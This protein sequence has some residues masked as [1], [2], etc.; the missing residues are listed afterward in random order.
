MAE[1][2]RETAVAA[3]SA[4]REEGASY[5]VNLLECKEMVSA[6]H[7]KPTPASCSVKVEFPIQGNSDTVVRPR[8][9][10]ASQSQLI[11]QSIDSRVNRAVDQSRSRINRSWGNRA[12]SSISQT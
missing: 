10:Q 4:A 9:S 8:A 7:R 12:V 1:R 5:P 2:F 11:A 3:A 6:G